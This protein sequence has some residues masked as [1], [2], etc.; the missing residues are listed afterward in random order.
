MKTFL[1]YLAEQ[2]DQQMQSVAPPGDMPLDKQSD[3]NK[4]VLPGDGSSERHKENLKNTL[5]K[6]LNEKL[7][8]AVKSGKITKED[9]LM[10][11]KTE[12][13][14]FSNMVGVDPNAASSQSQNAMA[15]NSEPRSP[16]PNQPTASG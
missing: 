6:F 11:L 15:T 10:L 16:I 14:A 9:A 8:S 12:I 3:G 5:N 7:L 2:E 4:P 1:S 13:S